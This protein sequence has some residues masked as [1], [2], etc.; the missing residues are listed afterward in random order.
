MSTDP[1]TSK[2]TVLTCTPKDG[3]TGIKYYFVGKNGALRVGK[4]A[5]SS[6]AIHGLPTRLMIRATNY[7]SAETDTT[8]NNA[9]KTPPEAAPEASTTETDDTLEAD[10]VPSPGPPSRPT[11]PARTASRPR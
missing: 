1:R 7:Q 8:R 6:Y 4:N 10:G 3:D 11:R 5:S 2:Y 9:D